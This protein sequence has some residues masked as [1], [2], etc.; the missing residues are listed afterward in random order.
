MDPIT[1][2]I[3]AGIASGAAAGMTSAGLETA[4]K[5]YR[6]LKGFLSDKLGA[7]HDLVVA[8]DQ[9]ENKPDSEARRGMVAEEVEASGIGKDAPIV[10]LA[11]ALLKELK[12]VPAASSYVQQTAIGN[13]IAQA[14]HGGTA[15]VNVGKKDE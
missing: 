1:A 14:S 5:A 2:A 15:T 13:N 9:L 10:A 7:K 4:G 12:D 6:K 8:V 11:N 3:L